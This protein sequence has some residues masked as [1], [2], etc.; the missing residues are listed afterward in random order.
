MTHAGTTH[1]TREDVERA[2]AAL[3][4]RRHRLWS[5]CLAHDV[6]MLHL[7]SSGEVY[8]ARCCSLWSSDGQLLNQPEPPTHGSPAR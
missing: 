3:G 4:P 2:A 7:T 5:S 8:C 6:S 1:L